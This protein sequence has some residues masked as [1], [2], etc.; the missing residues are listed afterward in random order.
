MVVY[1]KE[2]S[3]IDYKTSSSYLYTEQGCGLDNT[4]LNVGP[5]VITVKEQPHTA[6]LSVIATV[7]SPATASLASMTQKS[8]FVVRD[9]E[10]VFSLLSLPQV[11]VSCAGNE[12]DRVYVSKHHTHT[13]RSS[14]K[15][16]EE[17]E[18]EANQ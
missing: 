1:L 5:T 15:E 13:H 18:K 12:V 8:G 4:L 16:E 3:C 6:P 11:E 10:G 2:N 9:G 14:T 7:T 17:E